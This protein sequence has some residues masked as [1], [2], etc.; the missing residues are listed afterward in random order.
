MNIDKEN[1]TETSNS[2]TKE[3]K[4][5]K[6]YTEERSKIILAP[7]PILN[8]ITFNINKITDET[9]KVIA[10]LTVEIQKYNYAVGLAANQI[11]SNKRIFV[12][13]Q[14]FDKQENYNIIP[15]LNAKIIS[16]SDNM[17]PSGEGCLSYPGIQRV[18]ARHKRIIVTWKTMTGKSM[19]SVIT[20][21]DSN[22]WQHEIE[23]LDG[24]NFLDATLWE[25]YQKEKEKETK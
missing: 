12:F 5:N 10:E 11:G 23:H 20:G 18:V 22:I 9:K 15:V 2:E 19:I 24:H 7:N 14:Y 25:V 21:Q 3:I 8:N 16:S 13:K 6:N 1:I 4:E 17:V